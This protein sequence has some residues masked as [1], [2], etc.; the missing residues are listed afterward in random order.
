MRRSQWIQFGKPW[1]K[2]REVVIK[3]MQ[4]HIQ[5]LLRK[6]RLPPGHGKWF[7]KVSTLNKQ[8]QFFFKLSKHH[9]VLHTIW[10]SWK[11]E[12]TALLAEG[13]TDHVLLLGKQGGGHQ[14]LGGQPA[15]QNKELEPAELFHHLRTGAQL[16]WDNTTLSFPHHRKNPGSH[17]SLIL[18]DATCTHVLQISLLQQFSPKSQG[19]VYCVQWGIGS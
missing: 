4:T 17:F 14:L 2:E 11:P 7:M 1:G 15:T 12:F 5:R 18:S 19:K 8:T 9:F 6:E 16:L 13:G 10:L 3:W